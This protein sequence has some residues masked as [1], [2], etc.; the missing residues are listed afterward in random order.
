MKLLGC[1][2][3]AAA[4]DVLKPYLIVL[5]YYSLI[6]IFL[7]GFGV[8]GELTTLNKVYLQGPQ[9]QGIEK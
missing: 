7:W 2:T 8:L 4:V 1:C 3:V 9:S 6:I 5:K